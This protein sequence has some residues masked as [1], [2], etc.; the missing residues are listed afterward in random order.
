MAY[1]QQVV[2]APDAQ[3]GQRLGPA[4]AHYLRLCAGVGGD[5]EGLG[6]EGCRVRSEGC[7]GGAQG[8]A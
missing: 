5:G 6:A 1:G 3:L 2:E 7:G 8:G 4:D